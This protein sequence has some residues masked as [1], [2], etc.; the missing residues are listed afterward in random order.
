VARFEIEANQGRNLKFASISVSSGTTEIVAAPANSYERIKVCSYVVVAD[1]A[2]TFKF[3]DGADLTGAMSCAIN[4]GVSAAGQASSP[5]LA[6]SAGS[7]LSIVT[8]AGFKG[9]LSYVIEP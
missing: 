9:H 6:A 1:A 2:G 4:G 8:T 3:S 5:W 7:A